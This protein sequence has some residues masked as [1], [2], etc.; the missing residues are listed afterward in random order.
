MPG[1]RRLD[2]ASSVAF[3]VVVTVLVGVGALVIFAIVALSGAPASIALA[4]LLA[5]V[6]VG[7]IVACYLWLD[8]YEPEP[9]MLLA[10][11]LLWGC[12]V[13]TAAAILLQGVG[14]LVGS[15]TE[16]QTLQIVA[17]VTEEASKGLFLILLLWW[18]RAELDG[19]LDGDVRRALPDQPVR[20]PPLHDVHRYRGRSRRQLPQ[21]ARAGAL[22][23]RRLR[24]RRHRPR[25]LERLD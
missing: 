4:T 19:V 22:A 25:D 18:R 5:A 13:A 14:G 3:T 2:A 11:G 8:R 15:F 23:A 24:V 6:P 17:P 10:S 16:R 12:F 9:R 21:H 7:P 20:A 1:T